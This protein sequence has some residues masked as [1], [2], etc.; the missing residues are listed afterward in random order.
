[1][2]FYLISQ[3]MLTAS[4]QKEAFASL[5]TRETFHQVEIKQ[6]SI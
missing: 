4:S 2:Q 5:Y 1:M 3:L 6:I